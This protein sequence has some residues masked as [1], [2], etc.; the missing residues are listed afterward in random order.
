M[1]TEMT[2]FAQFRHQVYRNLNKYNQADVLM[3]LVDALSSNTAAQSVVELS[4]HSLFRRHYTALYK[5][6]AGCPLNDAQ[7]A[8]LAASTLPHPQ[9]RRYWLFGVDV[10]PQARLYAV[11]LEDRSFVY[12]PTIIKGNKPVTLGHCYSLVASLPE[13][14]VGQTTTW[15]VPLALQRVGSHQ[16]KELVGARQ[17]EALLSNPELPFH[18]ALCVEV[19]DS[20][21]SKPDYLHANRRHTN[22]V[23]I[24]RVRG[25]RTF[26]RQ[27]NRPEASAAKG[28]PT[29]Y[30]DPF[31]LRDPQTWPTPDEGIT[32]TFI[33]RRGRT[34]QVVIQAWHNLLMHGKYQPHRIPMQRH[35][36]TLVQVCLYEEN[37]QPAFRQPLWLIAIGERR[38]ELSALD[39]YEAYR[40]RYDLEHFLRFGKQ[41]LLLD[42]FQTPEVEHE[43]NWW[44][45]VALAYLQLWAARTCA[46]SLPRPWERY[47]PASQNKTVSPASVQRDLSRIIRQI[48]T[49][50]SPPKR[51]GKSLGRPK[52][53]RLRPRPR[54]PVV[55]KGQ[56]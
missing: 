32:T 24:T 19:A 43:E 21:Y 30:G 34:Y 44:R 56:T 46:Q 52:G 36:F 2:Q 41:N 5:A 12:R 4:L 18:A 20:S 48:G 25:N 6:I 45:I 8:E 54:H 29:W 51:R 27:A 50:A 39:I 14:D 53:T 28:H 40:Q 37:G 47:L 15:V 1:N 26:Y 33:S 13:E 7:L 49:P 31:V 16:D 23:S 3:D 17:M 11:T 10:T 35:P 22:L 55:R 42:R 9:R 38:H